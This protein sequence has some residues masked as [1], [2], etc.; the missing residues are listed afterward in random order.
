MKSIKSKEELDELMEQNEYVFV[1]YSATW[2][3]PCKSLK[4]WLKEEYNTYPIPI[5][6]V[7]V[8]ELEELAQDI[9]GLPT[10]VGFHNKEPYI[11]TEGFNKQKLKPIFDKH[12]VLDKNDKEEE[13]ENTTKQEQM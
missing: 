7:D 8:E 2:C 12:I 6:V 1:I 10:L 11:R 9:S 3:G 13:Q 5:V 4:S